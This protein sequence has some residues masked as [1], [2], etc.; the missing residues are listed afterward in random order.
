MECI[1]AVWKISYCGRFI[2]AERRSEARLF[3][4]RAGRTQ[5]TTLPPAVVASDLSYERTTVLY[6][7]RKTQYLLSFFI[8]KNRHVV[9]RDY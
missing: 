9:C 8:G 1:N 3:V 2:V 4:M 5:I 7:Q 6:F